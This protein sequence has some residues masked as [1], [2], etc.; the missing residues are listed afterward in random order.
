SPHVARIQHAITSTADAAQYPTTAVIAP[1]NVN[2]FENDF[3][4]LNEV[5]VNPPGPQD[6]PN[7]FVEL[8]GAPNAL[9]TN[10][11]L[12]AINGDKESNPG[13]ATLVVNL[14][15]ERLGSS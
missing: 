10:V 1:V 14:T 9:L 7:E 13:T 15:G 4:L 3:V 11:Y 5:K 6:A 8:R 2:V 12:L